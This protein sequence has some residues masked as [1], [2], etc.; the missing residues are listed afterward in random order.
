MPT[1]DIYLQ[2]QT[3]EGSHGFHTFTFEYDR[4]VAVRGPYKLAIQWLKRFLTTK[5]SDYCAPDDG[6]DFPR[7]VGS[8]IARVDDLRD[9]VLLAIQDCNAQIY[10]IQRQQASLPLDEQL[11]TASLTR[12]EPM[13]ADGFQCWV[14]ISNAQGNELLV[15]LPTVP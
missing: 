4:T 6:T 15:A 12:F 2:G 3:A 11:Q 5:G 7:L 9:V 1:Y 13:G 10:A 8:N 14:T